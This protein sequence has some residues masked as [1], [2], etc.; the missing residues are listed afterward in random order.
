MNKILKWVAVYSVK[1]GEFEIY[2]SL[3]V[4]IYRISSDPLVCILFAAAAASLRHYENEAVQ[5][6]W[7]SSNNK[8]VNWPSLC[9]LYGLPIQILTKPSSKS[10][11]RVN[12][13]V[14]LHDIKMYISK[15]NLHFSGHLTVQIGWKML[16]RLKRPTRV[17]R[18]FYL[19]INLFTRC[20]LIKERK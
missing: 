16:G 13:V 20:V 9:Q 3:V 1:V 8:Y 2:L 7:T 4:Q 17:L 18:I 14:I 6:W 19:E 15:V 5:A 10:W 12:K 11:V